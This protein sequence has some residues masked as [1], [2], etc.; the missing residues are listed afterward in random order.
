MSLPA[1]AKRLEY[2]RSDGKAYINTQFT[3]NQDTRVVADMYCATTP[4]GTLAAYG[5]RT[6]QGS[7]DEFWVR[8]NSATQASF[9]FKTNTVNSCAATT[10]SKMHIDQ[11]KNVGS[12]NGVSVTATAATFS[13]SYPLFI[14][15]LNNAGNVRFPSVCVLE[16]FM[17]F[18]N[19]LLER[20][21][22]PCQL[23]DGSIGLWDDVYGV[24]YGNAGSG[25]F[26]AGP[27]VTEKWEG[28]QL[29]YVESDGSQYVDT[30]FTPNQD[31]RVVL[32]IGRPASTSNQFLFGARGGTHTNTISLLYQGGIRS[33][34]NT[35]QLSIASSTV[36]A[37][38][39]P[40]TI[41][42]NKN[43]L[44]VNG[45]ASVSH[46]YAAFT[47]P[48]P[49]TLFG[50]NTNGT[51]GTLTTTDLYDG[52]IYD[53]GLLVRDYIPWLHPSGV[54][55]LLDTVNGRFYA[56]A[57]TTDLIAG[58]EAVL[59]PPVPESLAV[60]FLTPTSVK[61]TWAAS[62][63]ATGYRVYRDGVLVSDQTSLSFTETVG[64]GQTYTYGVTAY[65]ADGESDAATVSILTPPAAPSTLERV[66]IVKL[67]WASVDCDGYK[68][69]RDGVLLT[70]TTAT[71]YLDEDVEENQTY[72][73]TLTAY[74]SGGES[75]AATLSVNTK[76]GYFI[77]Q[78]A[79]DSAFFQ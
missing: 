34:W 17:I 44:T 57:S 13:G 73:Y 70:T 46:T 69:Y 1:G 33:D 19:G 72:T 45:T 53:N 61:L 6:S 71:N 39:T 8:I 37:L 65:S 32:K 30:Q 24:F 48:C 50:V 78:P 60:S 79:V 38:S 18:Q 26:T 28:T 52:Q 68:L 40:L 20:D 4:S 42:Q 64:S 55:G 66:L 56:S 14:F 59:A 62:E 63:G 15:A 35:T 22:I 5:S 21:Y 47:A 41:D 49:L 16:M 27:E 23:A 54:A 76:A 75:D 25:S 9:Y 2:I 58:P 7:G 51:V 77:Y 74:N 67:R 10:T 36:G 3:P 11:N 31:T 43:V 12:V 29:E